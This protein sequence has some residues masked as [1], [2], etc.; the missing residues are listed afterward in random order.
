MVTAK[1]IFEFSRTLTALYVEDDDILREAT[2]SFFEQFFAKVDTAVDGQQ[3]LDKYNNN[4]YNVVI[5]DI[6]MP[7]MN[8]INMSHHIHDINPDQKILVI[9]AHNESDLLIN[10]IKN[11]VSSFILKPINNE[12]AYKALYS[13][14]RDARTS[15]LNEELFEALSI[16]TATLEKQNLELKAQIDATSIK[17]HQVEVL[18]EETAPPV[19]KAASELMEDYFK[20]DEDE[21]HENVLF[22]SDDAAEIK[23]TMEEVME[24]ASIYSTDLNIKHLEDLGQSFNKVGSLFYQY[25]PFLDPLASSMCALGIAIVNHITDFSN[26]FTDNQDAVFAL[27]NAVRIDIQLYIER[28]SVESMAMKNIHH[29]HHPTSLSIQQVIGLISPAEIEEGEMEF[30]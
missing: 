5:T 28:F 14:C 23:E 13:V 2:L 1:A 30:F 21:G 12:D 25:T 18:L 24:L 10:L 26:V 20:T 4:H 6:N 7:N 16:Q 27:F 19:D 15:Q 29:I 22:T 9:S 3:G 8:G 11:G 17:N